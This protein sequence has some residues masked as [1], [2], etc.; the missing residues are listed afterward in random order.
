[1]LLRISIRWILKKRGDLFLVLGIYLQTRRIFQT[2]NVTLAILETLA[3]FATIKIHY[4]QIDE[5]VKSIKS[6][7]DLKKP[8]N[9]KADKLKHCSV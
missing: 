3:K 2:K 5:I 8:V 1:M 9:D 6:I 4:S 7:F